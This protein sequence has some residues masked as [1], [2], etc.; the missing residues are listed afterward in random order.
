MDVLAKRACNRFDYESAEDFLVQA[1][2]YVMD[3][4]E[5]EKIEI[6]IRRVKAAGF[7]QKAHIAMAEGNTEACIACLKRAKEATLDPA[8]RARMHR[9]IDYLYSIAANAEARPPDVTESSVPRCLPLGPTAGGARYPRV[10]RQYSV[11]RIRRDVPRV[12]ERK[13]VG[14]GSPQSRRK[15]VDVVSSRS[16]RKPVGAG[17][18]RFK[19]WALLVAATAIALVA[20][21]LY[22]IL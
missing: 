3:L 22:L 7:D 10:Q 1:L 19:L 9:Q 11:E 18:S 6:R 14:A 4:D 12:R 2:S 15:T 13:P 5:R 17:T 21:A 20:L 8:R 16:R